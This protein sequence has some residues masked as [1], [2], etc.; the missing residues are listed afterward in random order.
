MGQFPLRSLDL[1]TFFLASAGNNKHF[2]SPR[3]VMLPRILPFVNHQL[4]FATLVGLV[5]GQEASGGKDS[6][7]G[8]SHGNGGQHQAYSAS[9][10]A[11]A[12]ITRYGNDLL[13][14]LAAVVAALG[15][16]RVFISWTRYIR[17]VTCLNGSTQRYFQLPPSSFAC[18]KQHLL[19]APLFRL[20]HSR[21]FQ[22][23]SMN[24]GI[25]PTRFQSLFLIGLVAANATCCAYR[26][27]WHGAQQEILGRLRE[28]TGFLATVNMIPLVLLAGRNNPLIMALNV[29]FDTFNVFHRYLGRI[30]MVEA[31]VHSIAHMMKVLYGG[32]FSP[33]LSNF[34]LNRHRWRECPF[35]EHCGFS[36]DNNRLYCK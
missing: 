21:E 31:V 27:P 32:M 15:L 12:Q 4:V 14:L 5:V 19:D 2:I 22:L 3:V 1:F 34:L 33:S 35:K 25:L 13:I 9:P 7:G 26:I 11:L 18:I 16:Y 30:V 20:R 36:C 29:S 10:E 8:P 23:F 28:R 17:V 6:G 24:L